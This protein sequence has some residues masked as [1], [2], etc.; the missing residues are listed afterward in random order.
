MTSRTVIALLAAVSFTGLAHGAQ[1]MTP[2][3]IPQRLLENRLTLLGELHGTRQIPEFV[4]AYVCNLA[5]RGRRVALAL[6]YAADEQSLID[7]YLQSDGGPDARTA[8][9]AKGSWSVPTQEQDGRT[10]AAMLGLLD[11]VRQNNLTSPDRQIAV[12]AIDGVDDTWMS[13]NVRTL[14]LE[15]KFSNIVVLTGDIHASTGKGFDFDPALEPMGYLLRDLQ[16]IS[17]VADYDQGMAWNCIAGTCKPR[18]TLRFPMDRGTPFSVILR[19]PEHPGRFDGSFYVGKIEA[20][21][22]AFMEHP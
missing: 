7:A 1:C 21:M 17:L 12:R 11:A 10:S 18:L 6:E 5:S 14:V 15:N 9:L 13:R 20:S 4:G 16:P 19:R 8:L 22:P 3:E 2:I